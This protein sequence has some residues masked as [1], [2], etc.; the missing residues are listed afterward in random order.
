MHLCVSREQV[1][2]NSGVIYCAIKSHH[3]GNIVATIVK[4]S[5]AKQ[6]ELYPKT[7]VLLHFFNLGNT[8]W[9]GDTLL[10]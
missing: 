2:L 6:S 3:M 4:Q 1:I 8:V 5:K 10:I 9:K 7:G